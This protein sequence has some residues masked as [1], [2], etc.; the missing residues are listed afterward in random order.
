MDLDF[1]PL[2][3]FDGLTQKCAKKY[4]IQ[5]PLFYIFVHRQD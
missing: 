4:C 1:G 2:H 5:N 3:I